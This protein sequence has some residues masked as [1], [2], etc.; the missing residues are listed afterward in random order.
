MST[1]RPASSRDLPA[2]LEIYNEAVRTSTAT[3]ATRPETLRERRSWFRSHGR[4]HPILVAET[5]GRV[6]GWAS[7]SSWSDR[8]GYLNTAEDSFYVDADFQ[9]Q[10]IGHALLQTLLKK[11]TQAGHQTV[12]AR[13]CT[14]SRASIHLHRRMGFRPA[15]TLK[16]VGWKFGRYL[17]V[18]TMQ[19]LLPT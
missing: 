4:R 11:A 12:I 9:G 19:R 16:A 3:F 10:G 2:I 8:G 17:D 5:A 18:L 1:L 6:V 15:G 13:M 14:E 7:L